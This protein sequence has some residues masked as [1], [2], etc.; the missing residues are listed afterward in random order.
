MCMWVCAG[1]QREEKMG[2]RGSGSGRE[3]ERE[4]KEKVGVM[5]VRNRQ[6]K[7]RGKEFETSLGTQL[8]STVH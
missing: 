3:R 6:Q 1:L 7:E 5:K 4:R 8:C 2:E